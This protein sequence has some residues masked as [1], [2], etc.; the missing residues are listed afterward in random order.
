MLEIPGGKHGYAF[1]SAA[2]AIC[3]ARMCMCN[4]A[5]HVPRCHTLAVA[6]V[7]GAGVR[8]GGR[9]LYFSSFVEHRAVMLMEG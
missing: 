9:D 5:C 2:V 7:V 4:A 3:W 6:L 1:G 8:W